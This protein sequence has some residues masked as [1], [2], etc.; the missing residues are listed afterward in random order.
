M[1]TTRA[2]GLPAIHPWSCSFRLDGAGHSLGMVRSPRYALYVVAVGALSVSHK[3]HTPDVAAT[4][5]PLSS[6]VFVSNEK[7]G[8][9]AL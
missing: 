7:S 4:S 1:K 3:C 5:S 8:S 9:V 2:Y 6:Y